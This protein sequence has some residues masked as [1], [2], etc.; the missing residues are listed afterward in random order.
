MNIRKLIE[1][2]ETEYIMEVHD[3]ASARIVED[4]GF[5]AAWCSSFTISTVKGLRDTNELTMTEAL[6]TVSEITNSTSIDV[7]LDAD[8]GYGD[9]NNSMLLVK[10]AERLNIGGICV[11][12]KKFPKINSLIDDRNGQMLD[13]S[14]NCHKIE[15]M[16]SSRKN[17]DFVIVAR[18]EGLIYGENKNDVLIRAKAYI[19][20]G[21][22]AIFLHSRSKDCSEIYNFMQHWNNYA[23]VIICPTTYSKTTDPSIYSQMGISM[24]VWGNHML[25]AAVHN[26]KRVAKTIFEEKK[27]NSIDGQ[28]SSVQDIFDI[29]RM[30]EYYNNMKRFG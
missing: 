23:P 3:A 11:E 8:N 19:D 18:T 4:V 12:D 13:I 24:V 28:I 9:Y 27:I 22:D 7:L 17:K 5:K 30:D 10:K 1:S 16:C 14:T 26:M 2:K 20:A 6:E 15:A 29:Q 25:R 21:A